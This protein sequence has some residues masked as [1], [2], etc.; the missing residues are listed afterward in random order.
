MSKRRVHGQISTMRNPLECEE[1]TISRV[2][3]RAGTAGTVPPELPH[4]ATT[5]TVKMGQL[6]GFTWSVPAERSG[7]LRTLTI[8][9]K[10]NLFTTKQQDLQKAIKLAT[11]K[12]EQIARD[13]LIALMELVKKNNKKCQVLSNFFFMF[14]GH[15]AG[16]GK[17][18]SFRQYIS[19]RISYSFT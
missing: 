17:T 7:L 6:Q 19:F 2:S 5:F 12:N 15:L 16:K 10:L 11:E 3:N 18:G 4:V 9:R 14:G 13:R 8:S 1:S